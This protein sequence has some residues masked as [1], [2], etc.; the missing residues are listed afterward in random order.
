MAY[1]DGNVFARIVRGEI[2][3]NKIYENDH[4]LSFHDIAPQ[5]PVHALVIPKGRYV[6][7]ADFAAAASAEEQ[8]ALIR[9]IGETAEALGLSEPG[10]RVLANSGADAHQEV[11]HLHFHVFAGKRLGPMLAGGPMPPSSQV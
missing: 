7:M 3:C 2:P 8:S 6:S 11:M 9:A 5:A 4:A 10:Y 1:D